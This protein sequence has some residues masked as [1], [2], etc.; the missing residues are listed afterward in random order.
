MA[1]RNIP[2]DWARQRFCV[3]SGQICYRA[4]GRP[5]GYLD[6]DGYVRV[7]VMPY[8]KS[9]RA[10]HLSW[11]LTEGVW[12]ELSI[13]HIDRDRT[14]N[15]RANLREADAVLQRENTVTTELHATGVSEIRP[16]MRGADIGAALARFASVGGG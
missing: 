13:D 1:K 3:A 9:V 8:A 2:L 14:N 12:P 15:D 11:F 4:S 16:K 5:A 6:T 10:H 7:S